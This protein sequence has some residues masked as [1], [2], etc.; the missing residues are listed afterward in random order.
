MS[1]LNKIKDLPYYAS[2]C[3]FQQS[4]KYNNIQD[5]NI[6]VKIRA[7]PRTTSLVTYSFE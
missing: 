6:Y 1:S 4:K 5:I 2:H 3:N 7:I